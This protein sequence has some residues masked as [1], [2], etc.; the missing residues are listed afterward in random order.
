SGATTAF[1]RYGLTTNYGSFSTTNSLAA[2]N[3]TLSVSNLIASLSPGTTYHFQLVATN[4][5]GA[6]GANLSFTTSPLVPTVTTLAASGIT[7]TNATLNGTVNP[8]SGA[9]TAYFRY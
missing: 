9:T 5:A 2:T 3:T 1:F 7:A 6:A 4:S 8:G